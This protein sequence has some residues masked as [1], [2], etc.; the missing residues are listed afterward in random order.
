MKPY[1][2]CRGL[3]A[4]QDALFELMRE[5]GIGS[6]QIA[7]MV[8]HGNEQVRVQFDRVEIG[9]MLD[10][11]FSM[12][13]ALAAGA[14]SGRGTLDQFTMPRTADPEVQRLMRSTQVLADR[15]LKPGEYPALELVLA[16]GR[17]IERHVQ[18][19][20]GRPGESAVRSRIA[21]QS[22]VAGRACA[23]PRCLHRIDRPCGSARIS[24]GLPRCNPAPGAG[25]ARSE[26][27]VTRPESAATHWRRP[28]LGSAMLRGREAVRADRR[29]RTDEKAIRA[30]STILNKTPYRPCC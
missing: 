24:E 20:Q 1:A 4:C 15:A 30:Q 9:N 19:R 21:R 7:G 14:T 26:G 11:Q 28:F 10:A 2:C 16:D 13:Y 12:Q 17:R 29:L 25:R 22:G 6:G 23:R 27:G 8:V 3:H 5:L 18:I